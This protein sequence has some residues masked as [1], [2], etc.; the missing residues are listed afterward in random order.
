M[1]WDARTA[2]YVIDDHPRKR[3]LWAYLW[4]AA[5]NPGVEP[6][7]KKSPSNTLLIV[8]A[9]LS[10]SA[11]VVIAAASGLCNVSSAQCVNPGSQ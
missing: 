5:A 10:G 7:R 4:A 8:G 1:T 2:P 6:Q 11:D 9:H 3:I